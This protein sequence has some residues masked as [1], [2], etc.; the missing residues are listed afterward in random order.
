MKFWRFEAFSGETV[1][2]CIQTKRIKM[3]IH[4]YSDPESYSNKVIKEKLRQGDG[5]LLAD[6]DVDKGLGLVH[7]IGSMIGRDE[8]NN[9]PIINW[10]M[11]KFTLVPNPQGGVAQWKKNSCFKF[12]DDPA[13]RYGLE[14]R[15]IHAFND[16]NGV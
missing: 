10:K 5:I 6:F 1:D 12:A 14:K 13:K 9:E 3:P 4:F 7:A 15:F 11:S 8:E 16:G 2:E